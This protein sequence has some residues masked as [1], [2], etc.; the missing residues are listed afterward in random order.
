MSRWQCEAVRDGDESWKAKRA[1]VAF[2]I[3]NGPK[4]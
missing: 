1:G 3:I 4:K 2:W